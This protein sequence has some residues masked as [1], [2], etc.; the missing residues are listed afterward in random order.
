[1]KFGSG[2]GASEGLIVTR[3]ADSEIDMLGVTSLW[4]EVYA[5]EFKWLGS[6][7]DPLTDGFHERSTYY[8]AWHN[9]VTPVGTMRI[10]KAQDMGFHIT[11]AV[12]VSRLSSRQQKIVEVQ[13]LMV[14]P[15]YRDKRFPGAPFGIYGC[16]VKA[17]LHH[18]IAN[19]VDT[20][21]ADCHR[22]LKISPLKS[23]K[24]MGF[25]ETGDTY[26]DSM[27]SL[28]CVVLAIETKA[29]LQNLYANRSPFNRYILDMGDWSVLAAKI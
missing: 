1:M 21:L 24:Q 12:N 28:V 7:A 26:V 23:M 18:A 19:G 25:V 29:W 10:V 16:M 13:R 3:L 22:D 15:R 11:D 27:N 9:E 2:A 6:E 5:T 8:I 14:A 20:V 17:C 4:R